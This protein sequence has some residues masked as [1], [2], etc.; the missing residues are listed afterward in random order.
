MLPSPA[1]RTSATVARRALD[2]ATASGRWQVLASRGGLAKLADACGA[3]PC[4]SH[5]G[6]EDLLHW[7][8]RT[9]SPARRKGG[10]EVL[11][12][13]SG[14]WWGR[15]THPG[16]LSHNTSLL[17]LSAMGTARLTSGPP[18]GL[19]RVWILLACLQAPRQP[20]HFAWTHVHLSHH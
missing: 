6:L 16:H 3:G 7:A 12:S 4:P 10:P 15:P 17:G 14:S 1:A 11:A 19:L 13:W 2:G 8:E 18:V 9:L 5:S 20:H